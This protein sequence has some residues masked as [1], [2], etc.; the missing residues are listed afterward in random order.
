[1]TAFSVK[2]CRTTTGFPNTAVP[3]NGT[4]IYTGQISDN[5]AIPGTDSRASQPVS[6]SSQPQNSRTSGTLG[7]GE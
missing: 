3:T 6:S 7:P 5:G 1:M 4:Q 2:D